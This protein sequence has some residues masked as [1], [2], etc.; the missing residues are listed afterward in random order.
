MLHHTEVSSFGEV[1]VNGTFYMR[2]VAM[3]VG[4]SLAAGSFDLSE[5]LQY[6]LT[7]QSVSPVVSLSA[8]AGYKT[9][10]SS[11]C[12]WSGG[13]DKT[14]VDQNQAHVGDDPASLVQLSLST[15]ASGQV[16]PLCL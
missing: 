11:N 7:W 5:Q 10:R 4:Q 12:V 1:E 2:D 6:T 3:S 14:F 8:H 9:K 15:I 16:Q 13:D